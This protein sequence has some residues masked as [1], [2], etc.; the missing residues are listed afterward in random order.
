MS[1]LPVK[2]AQADVA[3]DPIKSCP[4]KSGLVGGMEVQVC[5][6]VCIIYMSAVVVTCCGMIR[7]CCAMVCGTIGEV[8]CG[9]LISGVS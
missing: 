2:S 6:C 4:A 5:E 9:V 8:N 7:K 3:R 1:Y